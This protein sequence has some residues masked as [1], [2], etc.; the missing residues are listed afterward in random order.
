M[1]V[2]KNGSTF[3]NQLAAHIFVEISDMCLIGSQG[4]FVS[5]PSVSVFSCHDSIIPDHVVCLVR[6]DSQVAQISVCKHALGYLGTLVYSHIGIAFRVMLAYI[7]L[8][9]VW[10]FTVYIGCISK[11]CSATAVRAFDCF[12]LCS[13]DFTTKNRNSTRLSARARVFDYSYILSQF[14][15]FEGL[16]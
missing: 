12:F 3:I 9:A 6:P 10:I 8:V 11:N 14:K 2:L 5:E 16:F 13:H 7:Q 1:V 15:I 4:E